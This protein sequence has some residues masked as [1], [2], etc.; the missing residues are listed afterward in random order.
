MNDFF[1]QPGPQ[2]AAPGAGDCAHS[3]LPPTVCA[4]NFQA[5]PQGRGVC[6]GLA[7]VGGGPVVVA[8]GS[9]ALMVCSIATSAH[10]AQWK[11]TKW[12]ARLA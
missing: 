12:G 1:L 2:H 3:Y 6:C 11:F 7:G 9:Y 4:C 8:L 10:A 5:G